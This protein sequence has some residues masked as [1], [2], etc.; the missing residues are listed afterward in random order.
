MEQRV[1]E[2]GGMN[3]QPRDSR[4]KEIQQGD[5]QVHAQAPQQPQKCPRC[6]SLNTK[7]CYYNNYSL[8]QPRYFCKTCRR[9]WTQGGTLRNVPVGGGCRKGKRAKT[10]NSSSSSE[11]INSSFRS[12]PLQQPQGMVVQTQA[13]PLTSVVKAK[14]PSSVVASPF[15][16]SGGYL[17]S[18]AAMHSLNPSS[19]HPFDQSLN[20]IAGSDALRSSNLGLLSGFNVQRPIGQICPPYLYHQM[21][22]D[23]REMVSL[24]EQG[25]VNPSS[26]SMANTNTNTNGSGVSQHDWPQSFINNNVS[27][28]ASDASLW[29][30]ISTTIGGNSE[31]TSTS[32]VGVDVGAGSSSFVTNQWP[33]LPGYGPPP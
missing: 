31:R 2:G 9:Y 24:Y 19:S 28:R 1:G 27:N 11:N 18:L 5:A 13:P 21:G 12:L 7:F 32:G 17:S 29:S 4:V 15:Y 26:S 20:V 14:D 3:K 33:N 23:E 6:D 16:Q 25:L 22:S 10:S 8:S 30:T